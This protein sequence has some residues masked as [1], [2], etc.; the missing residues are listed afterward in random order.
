MLVLL[1][2]AACASS[3]P[4]S[5]TEQAL[6]GPGVI[7]HDTAARDLLTPCSRTGP[8]KVDSLWDP[9]PELI[10]TIEH[11]LPAALRQLM[12]KRPGHG[13]TRPLGEFQGQY[14]GFIGNGERLVY[15]SYIHVPTTLGQIDSYDVSLGHRALDWCG[16]GGH[17]FGLVYRPRDSLF[18]DL[19]RNVEDVVHSP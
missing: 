17:F 14:V 12:W 18:S 11:Q 7:L 3:L 16:G 13:P 1:G 10:R 19:T 2:D 6:A 8:S 15:A 4:R 5:G 9:N